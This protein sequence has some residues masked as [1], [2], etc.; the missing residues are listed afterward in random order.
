M[1]GLGLSAAALAERRKYICASDAGKI[2]AGDARAVF[3]DKTGRS[4][5][6]DLSDI[7]AVQMGSY[8]EPFN[9]A[10]CMKMTGRSVRYFS[11][12]MLMRHAWNALTGLDAEPRELVVSQDYPFMACNLDALSTT[13][14]GHPC[15]LDAKHVGRAD[16]QALLRYT[17]AMTH[18]AT[19][20]GMDWWGLSF[21]VGNGKWEVVYQEIDPI[22]QADLIARERAL[23]DCVLADREP[24]ED[25]APVLPPKPQP[26]LRI[27]QLEDEFKDKW[28]NWASEFLPLVRQFVDTLAA[29]ERHM[30]VRE[31]MKALPPD[32]VGE[33][34]RGRFKWAR[35]KAGAIRIS[36]KKEKDNAGPEVE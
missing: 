18:Q 27:V 19:V 14:Q 15:V 1:Y 23:W 12:N 7:L 35:D 31:S 17:A 5:E 22:Y 16:E 10:W 32:D 24:A 20:C 13:P 9:L 34:T 4:E 30:I 11:E 8:T 36:L 6:A 26:R 3:L 25:A 28:P 2:M 33:I 29:H 21:F